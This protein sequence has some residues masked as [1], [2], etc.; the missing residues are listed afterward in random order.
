MEA[1]LLLT[2]W[3]EFMDIPRLLVQMGQQPLFIDGRR[4]LDKCSI[5]KYEG[6]GL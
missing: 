2:R 3:E 4:M 1:I 6:I 5:K